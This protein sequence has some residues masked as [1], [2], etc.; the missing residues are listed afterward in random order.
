[1][2]TSAWHQEVVKASSR[3]NWR[4]LRV[5]SRWYL[6]GFKQDSIVLRHSWPV[7]ESISNAF[8]LHCA[9]IQLR[10]IS[11][12]WYQKQVH[13]LGVAHVRLAWD[14]NFM[15]CPMMFGSVPIARRCHFNR[16]VNSNRARM[17]EYGAQLMFLQCCFSSKVFQVFPSSCDLAKVRTPQSGLN[18]PLAWIHPDPW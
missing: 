5:Y 11:S 13:A 6:T 10:V 8:R 12:K 1:M 7:A 4:K 15:A 9:S 16:N 18:Y 14:L 3:K 2:N 17:T